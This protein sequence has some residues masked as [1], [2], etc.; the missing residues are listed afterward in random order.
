MSDQNDNKNSSIEQR[1]VSETGVAASMELLS[2]EPQQ[3]AEKNRK[4]AH[5][6]NNLLGII[7]GNIEMLEVECDFAERSQAR[8]VKINNAIDSASNLVTALH[9]VS[10]ASSIKPSTKVKTR[11]AGISSDEKN[12]QS[13]R[14]ILIVDDEPD[15]VEIVVRQLEYR[16][17]KTFSAISAEGA[18]EI[19]SEESEVDLLFS[20]IVMN[21]GMNGFEL[22]RYVND[23]YPQ[24][25]ILLTTGHSQQLEKSQD[26]Q[27]KF[28]DALLSTKLPKPYT[29]HDLVN[30]IEE[31]L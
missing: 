26:S 31:L 6:L 23:T 14:T 19:L 16:G 21:N 24:I 2:Q 13:P 1:A 29:H 30:A 7:R 12:A 28:I 9:A 22:A 18:L 27:D 4:T 17:F 11:Q 8:L 10:L 25:K 3:L 15:L 20:D 5:Q